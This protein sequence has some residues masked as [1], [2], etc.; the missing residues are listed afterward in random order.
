MLRIPSLA[1][2]GAVGVLAL[3]LRAPPAPPPRDT[4]LQ[5]VPT[6]PPAIA[7]IHA[8]PFST[9]S[10]SPRPATPSG[11]PQAPTSSRCSSPRASR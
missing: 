2:A 1:L 10:T 7:P 4:S 6:T 8:R 5:A 11:S 9:R 3:C